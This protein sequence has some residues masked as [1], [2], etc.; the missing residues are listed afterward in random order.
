M[1]SAGLLNDLHVYDIANM[2]WTDV[3]SSNS[4]LP[5]SGPGFASLNGKIYVQ[6]GWD[7]SGMFSR[8]VLA[9]QMCCLA[10]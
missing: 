9:T 8:D 5:R 4:P 3:A 1:F 10:V 6:G 7:G 2:S